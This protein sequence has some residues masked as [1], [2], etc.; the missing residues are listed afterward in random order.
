MKL[1]VTCRQKIVMI[2]LLIIFTISEYRNGMI[3]DQV[4]YN[5]HR[6]NSMNSELKFLTQRYSKFDSQVVDLMEKQ[7]KRLT[8]ME[9]LFENKN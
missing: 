6:I 3:R 5:T 9:Q 4:S 7:D 1:S 8:L 2:I